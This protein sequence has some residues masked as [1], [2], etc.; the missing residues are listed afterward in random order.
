MNKAGLLHVQKGDKSIVKYIMYVFDTKVGSTEKMLLF[1]LK[2]I[3][4][5]NMHIVHH[6]DKSLLGTTAPLQFMDAPLQAKCKRKRAS[7]YSA[8]TSSEIFLML[9]EKISKGKTPPRMYVKTSKIFKKH[10]KEA[11]ENKEREDSHSNRLGVELFSIGEVEGRHLLL[12]DSTA[13]EEDAYRI[14]DAETAQTGSSFFPVSSR[15]RHS[16]LAPILT[17]ESLKGLTSEKE[18]TPLQ[19]EHPENL[20]DHESLMT[21]IQLRRIVDRVALNKSE[22]VTDGDETMVKNGV[23]ISKFS[24][25]SIHL[26]DSVLE[27]IKR[28]IFDTHDKCVGQ[29]GVF[30]TRNGAPKIMTKFINN[31]YSYELLDEYKN[32]TK[33]LPSVKAMDWHGKTANAYVIRSFAQATPVV[34]PCPNPRCISRLVIVPKYAPGQAKDDPDHGFRVCVNALVNK[35]LKPDASTIPLAVDEIKKLSNKKYFLQ[36]DG[37]NAYWSIPVCEESKRL[38]AF[39]TPDGIYCWNML[40]MGAKPSSAVQQSAYLEAL[41]Q[42]IDYKEDG[43]LRDCLTDENGVR[44]KDENGFDKTLRNHF[45]VYC[46]DIC[47]GSDS[48][49]E[50]CELFQALI[51][52]CYKAGI[53]VKASKVKFGVEKVTFHNYTITKDGT[54]PKEANLCPIRNMED[55]KDVHQVKA[56]LGCCQ[57]MAQY[58]QNYGI[59]ASPLHMLTKVKT[60]FPTPWI[61]GSAYDI[62]FH[63][64]KTA[65]LDGTRF[66]HHQQTDKRLFIEV[67]ASDFGW[68]ACLYQAKDDWKGDPKD[69]G[70]ARNGKTTERNIIYWVSKAWTTHELQLPVFYRESLARLLALEKFRNQIEANISAGITLYTDHKPGLYEGSLSNKGQ[71][72]AWKLVENSDLLSIVQ[73]LYTPGSHMICSDPLSRLC[74]PAQGFFDVH[75]PKKIATLL[76]YLPKEVQDC[77]HFRAYFNKD[78]AAGARLIQKWKTGTKPVLTGKMNSWTVPDKAFSSVVPGVLP[79]FTIGTPFANT[80]VT[81]IRQLLEKDRPFAVLSSISLIPE[82][83][84]NNNSSGDD[85][86]K[87][88]KD[89]ARKVDGLSKI[90]LTPS[91]EA[92]LIYI[93]GAERTHEVLQFEQIEADEDGIGCSDNDAWDIV[94]ESTQAF[95]L[96]LQIA[97][98]WDDDDASW[99]DERHLLVSTRSAVN[100]NRSNEAIRLQCRQLIDESRPLVSVKEA[101][102]SRSK[103]PVMSSS[104]QKQKP[105]NTWIGR[106]EDQIPPSLYD[107][108]ITSLEGFPDGLMAISENNEKPRIVVPKD[109]VDRLIINTHNDI[110]HQG[111]NKVHHILR[112]LFF[113]PK[114][115]IRIKEVVTACE[116]CIKAIQRRR[117]MKSVFDS[118]G[119]AATLL[120]RQGYGMD[121]YGVKIGKT[122]GEILVIVDL[123]TRETILRYLP[124]QTQDRVVKALLHSVFYPKGVPLFMRSDNAPQLMQGAARDMCTYLG[125]DQIVTGG[126]NPRGNSICE[127]VNQTLGSMIRKMSDEDYKNLKDLLPALEHAINVTYNSAIGCTPFE[128]GHG[129]AA[130]SIAEARLSLKGAR[131]T[132]PDSLEDVNSVFDESKIKLQVELAARVL[133]DARAISEWHRRMTSRKL[134]QSGQEIDLKAMKVGAK[135]YFYKPPTI[136]DVERLGRKAKHIDHYVG[137]GTIK[138]IIGDRSFVIE[139]T[140]PRTG[141]CHE[142]QR[143]AGMVLLKK[144]DPEASDPSNVVRASS[145]PCMHRKGT[146]PREGEFIITNCEPGADTWYVAQVTEVL[147]DK[148]KVNYYSTQGQS[149]EGYATTSQD[150]RMARLADISFLRTW[151]LDNGR[152]KAT[153]NPPKQ[154]IRRTKDLWRGQLLKRELDR[155]ILVR[156]VGMTGAGVLDVT[157]ATLASQLKI[158][159][160]QGAGGEDDFV[161]KPTFERHM[162]RNKLIEKRKSSRNKR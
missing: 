51:H 37:A 156:N 129:L 138:E 153:T 142:F 157:T 6:M 120:P 9:Q 61:K 82:I 149:L 56:F 78:T 86:P 27:E 23:T 15:R 141:K 30:P 139:Y 150:S 64:L 62:A 121:F 24:K 119:P 58:V 69:E 114:M 47:A 3:R 59:I 36:A 32:G 122:Q 88:D 41:D 48:M 10:L 14:E 107:R 124:D 105:L 89:I 83:A 76:K 104:L 29:D 54:E 94:Q 74:S 19:E 154:A 144:P 44:L 110:L 159:H 42:Y 92:W 11:K 134:N 158:P 75:L 162:R 140:N 79:T 13:Q 67:D 73:N 81:E 99:E 111:H 146:V 126:H 113:W 71:L 90:I 145:R 95:K 136:Q 66:L 128:A 52:C 22:A 77:Q 39:H 55:L 2:A 96:S 155:T 25:E 131:G 117:H 102:K 35:C 5:S 101:A 45:A 115:D 38:T 93:P 147:L 21:E 98:D 28:I 123:A 20:E 72:S 4:Q 87:F 33:K 80:G 112:P 132:D 53:Q 40:L 106:Q 65:M 43:T 109:E 100:N 31:P 46:D 7:V 127:R 151:C 68:G 135:A 63:R 1:S 97:P 8:K 85:K 91:A 26:G 70:E 148:I 116:T 125:I 18:L 133:E 49:E 17:Y 60:A 161:D 57:Q 143:D 103:A 34:E 16:V 137:P 84:R 130:R 50:L 160:H 118:Q 152:G 12:L 108:K